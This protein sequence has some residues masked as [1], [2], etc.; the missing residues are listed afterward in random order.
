MTRVQCALSAAGGEKGQP[1][2]VG[3][4]SG[5]V[6]LIAVLL[7]VTTSYLKKKG[8]PKLPQLR[9]L[10]SHQLLGSTDYEDH[11]PQTHNQ[12]PKRIWVTIP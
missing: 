11:N 2:V 6:I 10:T 12:H 3:M 1:E 4:G 5:R 7:T 8:E 9:L